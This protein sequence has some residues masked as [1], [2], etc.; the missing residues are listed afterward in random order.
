MAPGLMQKKNLLIPMFLQHA[1]RWRPRAGLV[2]L[3]QTGAVEKRAY[4]EIET[5][6][7]KLADAL[8]SYGLRPGDRASTLAWNTQRHFELFYAVS[9]LGAVLHTVNPRLF[10]DQ[11]IYIINHAKSR[12]LFLDP[13]LIPLWA[14]IKDR[15]DH[16]EAVVILSDGPPDD[17][18]L[19]Y[20]T[21][22]DSGG[23]DFS[24]P[25][26]DENTASSLCYT[27]GTTGEPKGV[28][29]SH[30]S[31]V[32]HAMAAA[33]NG[34]L[35]LDATDVIFP[36]ANMYHA[37][38]WAL[39]YVAPMTGASLALAGAETNPARLLEMIRSEQVT[40]AAGVPTIWTMLFDELARD[41]GDFGALKKVLIGGSTCPRAMID[42]FADQYGVQVLHVWGMTETSP[43]VTAST[44]TA[45]LSALDSKTRRDILARQG[46]PQ[47]GVDV[48]IRPFDDEGARQDNGEETPPGA[49]WVRGPWVAE[50]YFGRREQTCDEDGW[51]PTGDVGT[52]DRF[53]Y[54]R[55]T[56]RTKDLIKS[57][58]E[59][60]SSVVIENELAAHDAVF[61]GAVIGVHHPKWEERPLLIIQPREGRSINEEDIRRFLA[62]KLARWWM[63][64]AIVFTDALP[65][66]ATGKIDK[67][68][69]REKYATFLDQK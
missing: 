27:S 33:Q 16:I 19:N 23:E 26:F 68:A 10:H 38:G 4:P 5:R 42:K 20:E 22:I 67:K 45:E 18:F 54:L 6:A 47:F 12:L 28:L 62:P 13:D 64:D 53:G 46:R 61:A 69:L 44:P 37:N 30:R 55:I 24:W 34:A 60:I 7:R 36:I 43:I 2:C 59:W 39:P 11:I 14:E 8:K 17:S 1:A 31:T 63:P 41:G 50:S 25:E 3:T 49:I 21:L 58:G 66:T 48:D 57:G 9:G 29:Y 52:L 35:G 51:F 40:F 32:L 15:L 65:M 56:D